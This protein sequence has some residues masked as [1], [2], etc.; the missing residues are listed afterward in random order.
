[1][2]AINIERRTVGNR[3][4]SSASRICL[5]TPFRKKNLL[6]FY[7][8][9]QTSFL[10]FT[11]FQNKLSKTEQELSVLYATSF[12]IYCIQTLKSVL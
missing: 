6:A 4:S 1:M 2:N 3:L 5:S 8:K 11:E 10:T 12:E 7:V 9:E